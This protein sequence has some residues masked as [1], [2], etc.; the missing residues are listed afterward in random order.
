MRRI[1]QYLQAGRP[2]RPLTESRDIRAS[3]QSE[4]IQAK[5]VFMSHK[6]GDYV[7]AVS[8][9]QQLAKE[10]LS[11]YFV[12]DDDAVRP[13]DRDHLPDE[14]KDAVRRSAGLLVYASNRLL[15]ED[16]SWVCYEVGL[17]EMRDLATA[18]YT[19]T[20]RSPALLSP[21]RGLEAVENSLSAWIVKVKYA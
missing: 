18:R 3:I 8:V 16:A 20:N 7:D 1:R 5:R 13:G 15:D 14:I 12:E 21:I 6:T 4:A 19:V 9:G 10:G 17:A 2:D 11:V